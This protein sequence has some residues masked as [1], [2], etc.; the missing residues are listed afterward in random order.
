MRIFYE[1]LIDKY[2]LCGQEGHL[3]ETCPNRKTERTRKKRNEELISYA[4]V[5]ET[6]SV[7]VGENNRRKDVSLQPVQTIV[8]PEKT[9]Q[10]RNK[11][12]DTE[13][14]KQWQE[15]SMDKHE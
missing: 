14:R 3:R 2:F 15:E 10:D 13:K 4:G 6:G 11:V 12:E 5:I 8:D 1:E 9:E 7:S